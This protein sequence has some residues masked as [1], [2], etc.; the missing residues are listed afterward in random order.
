MA[1]HSGIPCNNIEIGD[2]RDG[3][4]PVN[5]ID[6]RF[7]NVFPLSLSLWEHVRMRLTDES[8]VVASGGT[9]F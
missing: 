2:Q 3:S 5:P 8:A 4:L 1:K 9:I 6:L 7:P